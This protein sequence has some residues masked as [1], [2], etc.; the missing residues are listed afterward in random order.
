MKRCGSII[1]RA[2][3]SSSTSVNKKGEETSQ[4]SS[5]KK[6][7]LIY[8]NTIRQGDIKLSKPEKPKIC[9]SFKVDDVSSAGPK[10]Y[11]QNKDRMYEPKP[12]RTLKQAWQQYGTIEAMSAEPDGLVEVFTK[13]NLL[14]KAVHAAFY[15]HHPL[16]LSPDIIWLTIAQG[17]ANHVDQNARK[18]RSKFVHHNGKKELEIK[19]FQF[20]KGS[21]K[22][23][24]EGVFPE[25]SD[26]I[27][28][29]S[30]KG[31]VDLIECD[32]ST[33]GP[34]E[35][36]VSHITLM[37]AVQHYFSYSMVC[38]C[39]FPEIALTGTVEDWEKIRSKAEKLR[40][41]DLSWW[42]SALLPALDQF[43]KAAKGNP[44][45]N[46]WRSLCHINTGLSFSH[47]EPI[48][49]WIQVFYPYLT[50]GK[51]H[52]DRFEEKTDDNSKMDL[53]KNSYLDNY[54][55][56]FNKKVNA[57]SFKQEENSPLYG[58]KEPYGTKAGVKLKYFPPSLS[59]A[60]FLYKDLMTNKRHSMAF[61]GGITAIVQH[62][63]GAI[64]PKCGWAVMDSEK[65]KRGFM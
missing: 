39:G 35:K 29:N 34:V 52:Y 26:L 15:G 19:R 18:L 45:L 6:S 31:I 9:F 1:K 16:I 22:N 13:Q 49:G 57:A 21:D 55:E 11:G 17:L 56:S 10:S 32:F 48:T 44:D 59:S 14:V 40:K 38:G 12:D 36:V 64:E 5:V 41:Y 60:P 37:D 58:R 25:F 42:L 2:N 53:R 30:V 61:M 3:V 7:P 20:V 62:S 24:W 8:L 51:Y 50:T 23:D 46:F 63:D 33:T 54:L 28:A 65:Y 27:R 4:I 47:Y 43:V